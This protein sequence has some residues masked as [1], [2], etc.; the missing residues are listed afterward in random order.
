MGLGGCWE[1]EGLWFDRLT[2][3]AWPK[4]YKYPSYISSGPGRSA[5]QDKASS[6]YEPTP[7]NR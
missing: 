7:Y 4:D 3:E 6:A 1:R 2:T 5:V